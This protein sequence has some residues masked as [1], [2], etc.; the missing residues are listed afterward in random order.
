MGAEGGLNWIRSNWWWLKQEIKV[1]NN[2]NSKD[3]DL[4]CLYCI[5]FLL[6]QFELVS[7]GQ[8]DIES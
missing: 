7:S 2:N 3:I 5:D 6:A 4:L 8:I 1:S